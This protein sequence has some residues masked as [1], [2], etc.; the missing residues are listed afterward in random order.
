[1]KYKAGDKVV[2][3]DTH[4]VRSFFGGERSIGEVAIITEDDIDSYKETECFTLEENR[5]GVNF[6]LSDIK[7]E[8][9]IN[10][11]KGKKR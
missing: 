11:W 5:W 1:M 2:I 6:Y 3:L 9:P 8:T 7:L 10:T 4:N